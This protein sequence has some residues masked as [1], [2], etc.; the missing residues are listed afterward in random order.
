M[1]AQFRHTTMSNHLYLLFTFLL[2]SGCVISQNCIEF[3]GTSKLISTD[4]YSLNQIDNGNFTFEAWVS[5]TVLNSSNHPTIFSNRASENEGIKFFFHGYW[6]GS[7]SKMLSVQLNS[8]NYLIVNNGTYNGEILDGL[9]HHVAITKSGSLLTFYVDGISF[10]TRTISGEV[11]TNSSQSIWIG[12]DQLVNST[13]NGIISH[14]RI[15]N[16]ALS[17]EQLNLSLNCDS[18]NALNLVAY[19][20]LNEGLGQKVQEFISG[21]FDNLGNNQSMD[22]SDPIWS[23]ACCVLDTT[24]CSTVN[25]AP[26][27]FEL[28]MPNVFTPNSDNINDL[29]TPIKISGVSELN[30]R[31]LNRWGNTVYQTS[32]NNI[33]WTGEGFSEGVYFYLIELLTS[34]G[35]QERVQG[36][37]HLIK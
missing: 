18:L 6:G 15:W 30:C 28:L 35:K 21:D 29:L 19:W 10:G 36:F 1:K 33:N 12:Q 34:S 24:D 20:K 17:E 2:S 14:L 16:F 37:F 7:N 9:C 32:D 13:F 26:E 3:D 25:I 23:G 22:A 31:I 4:N 27:D 8:I 11:S 5:G